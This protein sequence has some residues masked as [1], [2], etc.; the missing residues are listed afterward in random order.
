MISWGGVVRA[1]DERAWQRLG[2]GDGIGKDWCGVGGIDAGSRTQ[3][4]A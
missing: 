2:R 1:S 3:W 4:Q